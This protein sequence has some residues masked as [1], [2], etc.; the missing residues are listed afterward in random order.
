MSEG[1]TS[2]SLKIAE[3]A[4][5]GALLIA[6][7]VGCATVSPKPSV[8]TLYVHLQPAKATIYINEKYMGTGR[9]LHRKPAMLVPGRYLLTAS[10]PGYFPEDREVEL[11]DGVTTLQIELRPI[12]Q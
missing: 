5:L 3:R 11:P 9:V 1:V 10:S 6:I 8:A 4:V 12:P 7:G 2:Q